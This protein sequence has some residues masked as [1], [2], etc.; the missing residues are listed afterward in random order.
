MA[1]LATATKASVD[2]VLPLTSAE[3]DRLTTLEADIEADPVRVSRQLHSLKAK[4]DA[5]AIRLEGI[6]TAL[7]AERSIALRAAYVERR[8][9]QAA[10]LVAS[11]NL[12]ANEPLPSIG[13]E[14]WRSLWEAAR[15]YSESEAYAEQDFPVTDEGAR[16]LL[17]LQELP[18]AAVDRFQR[19]ETFV[20]N[21]SKRRE[22]NAIEAYNVAVLGLDDAFVSE[23]E[24]GTLL[25][26]FETELANL[27]LAATVTQFLSA[28]SASHSTV[29]QGHSGDN[30]TPAPRLTSPAAQIRAAGVDLQTRATGLT[31]ANAS[32]ERKKLLAERDE[33]VDRAWLVK[34]KSD[35]H[36]ELLR[37]QQIAAL[38]LAIKDT[39]TNKITS[40]STELAEKLVT[41]ALRSSF[42]K[43]IDKLGI[44][45]LAIELR[46]DK[47]TQGIPYFRV[48]LMSQPTAPV[49]EILSEG[50]HRC[51][52]IAAFLAE[53]GMT[54]GCSG[55]VFDD[56]VSSLDHMHRET[57]ATRLA[58]EG[59]NRQVIIFTHDLA[60]LM[61]LNEECRRTK[62]PIAFRNI[63]RGKQAA[64][65]CDL[66][67][68]KHTQTIGQVIEGMAKHLLN[69]RIQ[70][71]QGKKA[72]WDTTS[73]SLLE[74][75]RAAWERAVEDALSPVVKRLAN[76]V[77][78]KNLLKLT[79]L[80]KDDCVTMRLAFGRCSAL[81]HSDADAL[82]RP[83]PTPEQIDAEITTL[84]KWVDDLKLRQDA[85]RS[86]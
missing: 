47:T 60:F 49:G 55:L 63:N 44:A 36:A 9:S 15:R 76:K 59:A 81:L 53:V 86:E 41:N 30:F 84:S 1:G 17:C 78:T 82:N 35:I 74:Q 72:D 32:E 29:K 40:K 2:S 34:I 64:G 54:D 79:V 12:F 6:Q 80:T 51:V 16:C 71:E 4:L 22:E 65:Y 70:Y 10:S 20:K 68:P 23:M 7:D 66:N 73:R 28:A 25:S 43:E 18:P 61:L 31:S 77:D 75:L 67:G 42:A 3:R 5:A 37:K 21:E 57:V 69:T 8:D 62:T 24:Q 19:F 45:R 38:Q 13:S 27:E 11:T 39:A 58:E 85:V 46:Q 33:L 14:V 50:E 83:V 56:P 26:L 52:A 48:S